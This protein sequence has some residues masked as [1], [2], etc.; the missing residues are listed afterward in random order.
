MKASGK[1]EAVVERGVPYALGAGAIAGV[2]LA[3]LNF[4]THQGTLAEGIFWTPI[5][6][7]ITTFFFYAVWGVIGLSLSALLELA[8]RAVRFLA[9][10]M[11]VQ[12]H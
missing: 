3:V 11:H 5:I 12:Q 8:E 1:V 4:V 6:V 10:V 2:A 9:K 7:G